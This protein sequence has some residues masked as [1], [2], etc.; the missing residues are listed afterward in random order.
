MAAAGVLGGIERVIDLVQQLCKRVGGERPDIDEKAGAGAD[1]DRNAR[2]QV[3]IDSARIALR[4]NACVSW[5]SWAMHDGY[6]Q[7][8]F[9]AAKAGSQPAGHVVAER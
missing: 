8:E 2:E 9:V 7:H 3:H 6:Q 4:A 1:D 5:R